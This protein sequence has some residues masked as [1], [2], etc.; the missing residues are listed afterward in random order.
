MP[1]PKT[2]KAKDKPIK[3]TNRGRGEGKE[4]AA[5]KKKLSLHSRKDTYGTKKMTFYVKEELLER[6]Y[7]FAYWGRHTV[8]Q[9][10]NVVLAD[11][12]KGKDTRSREEK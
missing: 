9:A 5:E 1:L 4:T 3:K 7:N 11:G 6:L 10:F 2:S 12:L 8:T